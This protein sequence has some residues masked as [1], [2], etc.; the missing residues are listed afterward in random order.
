LI[1]ASQHAGTLLVLIPAALF[2]L[3]LQ[4]YT[5]SS[6]IKNEKGERFFF[7]KT[8]MYSIQLRL[9]KWFGAIHTRKD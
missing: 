8:R 3:G 4:L 2:L 1:H 6:M 9:E 7:N 5:L